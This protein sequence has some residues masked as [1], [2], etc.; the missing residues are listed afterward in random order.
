[1]VLG[2]LDYCAGNAGCDTYGAILFMG[3]ETSGQRCNS[4]SWELQH[5]QAKA[6]E[7]S[8]HAKCNRQT[9]H[10]VH[11]DLRCQL[12]WWLQSFWW[13]IERLIRLQNAHLSM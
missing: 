11:A 2:A 10:F 13:Q 9:C 7:G 3:G 12:Q 1:M 5:R 4:L 6:D 8:E